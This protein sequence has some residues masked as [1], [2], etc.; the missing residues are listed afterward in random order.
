MIQRKTLMM[1]STFN[2]VNFSAALIDFGSSN[3]VNH[4]LNIHLLIKA[5]NLCLIMFSQ[6]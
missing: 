5:I 1:R 2:K 3:F 4:F 6:Y